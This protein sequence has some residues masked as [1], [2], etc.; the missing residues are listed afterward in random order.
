[1]SAW[2]ALDSKNVAR[3][4][5]WEHTCFARRAM[6]VRVPPGPPS[7]QMFRRDPVLDG[8]EAYLIYALIVV[9]VIFFVTLSVTT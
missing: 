1:M 2:N 7:N 9:L 8:A 3:W 4:C 5:N 6:R